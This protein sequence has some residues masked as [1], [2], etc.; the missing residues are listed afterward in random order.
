MGFRHLATASFG[1]LGEISSTP[2]K[3]PF[4]FTFSRRIYHFCESHSAGHPVLKTG[5]GYL[6]FK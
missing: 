1:D 5:S 4:F 3:H 2:Q 6:L